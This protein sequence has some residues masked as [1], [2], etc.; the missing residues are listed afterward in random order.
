M[1]IDAHTIRSNLMNVR[2]ARQTQTHTLYYSHVER[3][4]QI[5]VQCHNT[6]AR[7]NNERIVAASSQR[8]QSRL[9]QPARPFVGHEF[10]QPF[11]IY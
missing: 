5:I 2:I 7:F 11:R 4:A 3:E 8:I 10:V 1:E 6:K 9:G